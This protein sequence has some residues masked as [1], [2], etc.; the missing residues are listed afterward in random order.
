M[1][2]TMPYNWGSVRKTGDTLPKDASESIDA[3]Y[4]WI[5]E[6]KIDITVGGGF[7]ADPTKLHESLK[8]HQRDTV[9]WM[10]ARGRALNASSFGMGKTRI[11][12]EVARQVHL[13]TGGKTLTICPLAVKSQF[14][15]EDGP[16]MGVRYQYVRTDAECEAADTPY[17]I[18]NY[19][20]VREGDISA[21]YIEQNI[22]CALLDEGSVL[23]SLGSKTQQIFS[24]VLEPVRYV[25]VSTA[26]P[27]PN[28]YKEII[29]YASA[30]QVMDAGQ[31]LTRWFRRDSQKAGNLTI[32]PHLEKEFWLWVASWALFVQKPSD[33]GYSDS[34]YTMPPLRIHWHRITSDH[35]KAWE[36][37]DAYGQAMLF[38]D[39]AASIHAAIREKRDS[40][41]GRIDKAAEI[42]NA[43]DPSKHWLVWHHLEDERHAIVK[44]VPDAVE[45]YGSQD[46]EVREQR[47]LDFSHG[48]YRILATK[49]EIAGSGCNFQRHCYANIFVGVRYQFEEFIQ[50]IHRTQRYGQEHPVEVH[51]I[52]TDAEDDIVNVL[53]KKWTQH[54][55]LVE[56]MTNII[57]QFGLTNEALSMNL[58]RSIGVQRQEVSGKYFI[59]VNNDNVVEIKRIGDNTVHLIHTSVPFDSH[60][61]YVASKNDF[62]HNGPGGY[63][64]QMDFLIPDL[65]RVLKPGRVAAIHVK[66]LIYYSY[67]SP[68]GL[69]EIQP[70]S[71]ETV[72]AFRKH[73]FAFVGRITVTTD[74]VRENNSTYRLTWSEQCKDGTKMGV[75]LPEYVLLFRKPPTDTSTMYADEPVVHTKDDY[76]VARWQID[77]HD[78]W[79]SSGNRPL[80][81]D[82]VA[83]LVERLTP[84]QVAAMTDTNIYN[85]Y[86]EFSKLNIY[87]YAEH[88]AMA[89]E[90][91]GQSRLPKTYGLMLPSAPIGA[92]DHV[93]TNVTSMRT[94][95]SEQSSRREANHVCP[96]PFDIVERI[97]ERFS[98]PGELILDPFGGLHTV[99]YVAVKMNRYG[100]GIELN[101]DY[102]KAGVRYCQEA[103]MERGSATLFDLIE[104]ESGMELVAA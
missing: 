44:A 34:G 86:R 20:R 90:L 74:V 38:K 72:A 99:P 22:E 30:L 97:I 66:D 7:V 29:Y 1:K 13:R 53:R 2:H 79:R 81:A 70:F 17:L 65:F 51:I 9:L 4:K 78:Y 3:Y 52:Y 23:R 42:I 64:A 83:W 39:S 54:N 11:Q 96:L 12:I 67:K 103:E 56:R 93:W 92:Q 94:L 82:E 95:N 5:S 60:Y 35:E 50:A 55:D 101:E 80:R 25:F 28:N 58:K 61:E 84:E 31:A 33:L 36:M 47:I 85:W 104:A 63:H 88:V 45:V 76:T 73:G 18:T 75:G 14:S 89:E 77:A 62:G 43:D 68:T 40:L 49:P 27:S 21:K 6:T 24:K 87:D 37:T 71:D 41:Q 26:T 69:T 91:D 46:L 100:Y 98:N 32:H 15:E 10:L 48:H 19:E 8:T 59:A 102:W 16:V 57:K